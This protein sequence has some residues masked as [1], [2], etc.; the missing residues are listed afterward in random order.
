MMRFLAAAVKMTKNVQVIEATSN[1]DGNFLLLVPF[2]IRY[3]S[4]ATTKIGCFFFLRRK[5]RKVFFPRVMHVEK[6]ST[7]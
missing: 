3:I 5:V 4:F 2:L 7:G 6:T 1:Q